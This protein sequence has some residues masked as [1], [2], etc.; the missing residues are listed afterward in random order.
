MRFAVSPIEISKLLATLITL[1]IDSELSAMDKYAEQ[2]SSTK[3]KSRVGVI[4]PN[5]I[6]LL[7]EAIWV[8]IVGITALALCLGP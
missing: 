2:V 1:P 8:I 3:L 7:P 5:L 6:I 4:E